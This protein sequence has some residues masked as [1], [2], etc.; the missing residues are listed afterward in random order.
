VA[1]G[2]ADLHAVLMPTA[3][4]LHRL[5]ALRPSARPGRM[6]AST[7]SSTAAASN[8]HTVGLGAAPVRGW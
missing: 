4:S 5:M 1:P 6:I 3:P 8:N 7:C 2:A